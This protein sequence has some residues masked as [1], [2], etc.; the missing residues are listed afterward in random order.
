RRVAADDH[1]TRRVYDSALYLAEVLARVPVH[2]I[3]CLIGEPPESGRAAAGFYADI[4]PATWSFML[5]ARA[6]GLGT[7]WTTMTLARHQEI[8]ALLDMPANVTQAALIPVAHYSGE[9]FRPAARPAP[10]TITSWNA[11]QSPPPTAL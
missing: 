2:V 9:T 6:R 1:Q 7:V 5:A 4:L 11:W 3:P 8:A 10:E